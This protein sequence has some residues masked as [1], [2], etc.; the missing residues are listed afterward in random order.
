MTAQKLQDALVAD[1]TN[2][3][4]DRRY[5]KPDG[6]TAAPSVFAQALP[7]Q[8]TEADTE[9]DP[10][11]DTETDPFPYLI[12]RIDSGLIETQTDPHKVSLIILAG[13][14]D[15]ATNNQGH[16]IILEMIEVIQKHYEETPLLAG[17]FTF[18]DPF[19]WALQD[20]DSFP[21]FFGGIEIT[22]SAPAPRRE[23]SNLT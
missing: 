22:F 19:S 9:T 23:W 13:A 16:R 20:E 18:I 21:Y 11:A 2:L 4:R 7:K 5:K 8:E 10:E 15:D 1:L 6:T 12:V 14:Y 3:F 17:Q